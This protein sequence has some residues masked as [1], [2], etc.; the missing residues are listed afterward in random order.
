MVTLL[1]AAEPAKTN[2][3]D[4][5][6]PVLRDKCLGCHNAEKSKGGLDLTNYVKLMAGGSSGAV[7]K[8]GDPDDSR[9]FLLAAHKAEPMM[10]PQGGQMAAAGL[11]TIRT[12][13][14]DGAAETAGS[15]VVI[16]N[17]A[18]SEVS[19]VSIT[20]GRPAGPPPMP[21]AALAQS[22]L[23]TQKPPAV[24]ALAASP[25]AP[26]LAVAA[27]KQV[28]LIH[29]ESWHLLGTLPFAHGQVNVLKFSRNGQLLLAGG[30]R[31]GKAGKVVVWNVADGKTVIEVGDEHDAVLAADISADQT[32]I[33]LGGPGKVIRVYST[34]DGEKLRDIK[35]HTDW[36]TAIEYSPDGVLLASGDRSSGLYVWEAFTGRE[37]FA[38]RGPKA[39]VTDVSWRADS[40]LLAAASEDGTVKLFEMENGKQT[41]SWNAHGG[42]VQAVRYSHDGRLVTCGRDALTKVWDGAGNLKKAMESLTDL[43]TRAA[44]THDD[45]AAV[46]GDLQG[47][48]R[49]WSAT[50]GA[51]LGEFTTTPLT[52][53][54]Q[55]LATQKLLEAK[56]AELPKA[57]AALAAATAAAQKANAELAAA[58]KA[59]ADTANISKVIADALADAKPVAE[60]AAAAVAP[61]QAVV[62]TRDV[63]AKALAEAAAKIKAA[64]DATPGNK[65]L[66]KAAQE[67]QQT[68]AKAGAD[69]TAAQK[70]LTDA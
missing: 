28:L 3:T 67:A 12:W 57:T 20:R 54:E 17:K 30:G 13:I 2:Y 38:L 68:A 18:K 62:Q 22:V 9:L 15:K 64:A 52:P 59:A 53:P 23:R 24:T 69:L 34:K 4:H 5:V 14:R 39:A 31:G 50:D 37:Y 42:G 70:A 51:R 36:V 60:R 11:D 1:T 6:L 7:V 44:F 21:A 26:L 66:A 10:P 49:V 40:N 55:L 41:K 25:W 16:A 65:E 19:L 47:R 43:A 35:K 56:G 8:P 46:A 63:T 29:A 58:Q 27:S 32:Q 45:S 33:A 61:A 48:L